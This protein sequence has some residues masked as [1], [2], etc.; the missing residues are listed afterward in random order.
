MRDTSNHVQNKS[1][2][3]RD[4]DP[5]DLFPDGFIWLQIYFSGRLILAYTMT[6]QIRGMNHLASGMYLLERFSSTSILN[7]LEGGNHTLC[8]LL[9]E[10]SLGNQSWQVFATKW[11]HYGRCQV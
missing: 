1:L 4:I 10:D 8:A 3:N 7:C 6:F 2:S 5:S 11:C 9:L